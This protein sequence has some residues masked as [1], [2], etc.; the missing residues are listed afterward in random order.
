MNNR[1]L[2]DWVVQWGQFITHDMDLTGTSEAN[3]TLF[4]GGT[5]NFS[6]PITDPL[7]PLSPNPIPFN[8]S[9]YDPATGTTARLPVP[10][11]PS[12][13]AQLARADQLGNVVH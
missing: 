5:G 2:S 8:R 6:I 4:S 10:G 3:N 11:P 13:P 9:N 7:D 12:D 1:N